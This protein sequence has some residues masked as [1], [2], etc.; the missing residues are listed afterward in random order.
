MGMSSCSAFG[1]LFFSF[2]GLVRFVFV[3]VVVVVEVLV[4]LDEEDLE[5]DLVAVVAASTVEL[6]PR[7]P[8]PLGIGRPESGGGTEEPRKPAMALAE[9]A[10]FCKLLAVKIFAD[11]E[12]VCCRLIFGSDC[13]GDFARLVNRPGAVV[14]VEVELEV[15]SLVDAEEE[16]SEW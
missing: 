12:E 6:K 8:R 15:D 13:S 2:A 5:E 7:L 4:V 10:A 3:V 11:E 16:F 9:L 1:F 14:E